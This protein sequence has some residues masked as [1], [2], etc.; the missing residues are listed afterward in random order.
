[1]SDISCGRQPPVPLADGSLAMLSS[2]RLAMAAARGDLSPLR[3][4]EPP[5]QLRR[6]DGSPTS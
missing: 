6:P 2:D 3:A 5:R 4:R 1:M